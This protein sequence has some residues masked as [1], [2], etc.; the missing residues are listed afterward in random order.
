MEQGQ[1]S[2]R[3]KLLFLLESLVLAELYFCSGTFGLSLA[4]VNKSASA[5][6]PPT[7][8]ALVALLLRGYRLWPAVFVGAFAV[9]IVAQGSPTTSLVIAAGNTLEALAGAWFMLRFAGGPKALNR[10]GTIFRF[11][12]LTAMVSTIISP[13]LGV[14]SLCAGG[15]AP[16]AQCGQ[17]W[18]TWWLGDMASNLIIAPLLLVWLINPLPR[19]RPSQLIE[20]AG[21]LF[22]V[23]W[24]G[25]MVFL[26]RTP[27]GPTDYP[28]EYLAILPLLWAAF[29]FGERGALT[30]SFIISAIALWGTRHG[31]GPFNRPDPNESLLLLQTFMGTITVTTL[32]LASIIS[33]RQ[34]A[35]ERL[36]VQDAVSRVLAE[37][38]TLGEAT[39]RIFQALCEKGGW[40][41]GALWSID[42]AAGELKCAEMWHAKRVQVPEFEAAT[43]GMRLARGKG[44]PGR[45]WSSGKP[46][47]VP[48]VVKDTNFP[49]T[50]AAAH[51][52]LHGAFCFPLRLGEE[53]VAIIECFSRQVREPDDDFLQLLSALG[54]QL[55]QFIERKRAEEAQA[56]LASI[57]SSSEDAIISKTIEGRITSWNRGAEGMF[58]YSAAEAIGREIS[59]IIPP[60]RVDEEREILQRIRGGEPIRHYQTVRLRKDGALID[61]SLS[62]SPIRD[63]T[64]TITGASKIARDITQEKKTERALT[65]AQNELKEYAG[66]LE[67]RV[68]ERTAKLRETI[69]SLDGFC[70]SIAHDLRAPLRAL[71]GFSKELSEG[72]AHLLDETGNDYLS[73]I[74]AAATR[75]DQLI[76]D[77]LQFGRLN[78]AELPAKTVQLDEVLDKVL[79]PLDDEIKT[80]H[81]RVKLRKPL[82]SVR[83]NP[84]MVEQVVINL[85]GNAL[86][87]VQPKAPPKVELW[88]EAHDS[89]VR[90]YV[91]D[92]GIGI[93]PSHLNK[94]FQPFVRLVNGAEYPGTGIG[95]AIVRKAVERMGGKVGVESEPGKG[96]C[97]WIDLPAAS[98]ENS[99]SGV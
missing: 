12:L 11:V 40:E 81:A 62:I 34:R 20:G 19:P 91:K 47:W 28:L 42:H 80:K 24:I 68:Q 44:L 26:G 94:L 50:A 15:Y 87:F 43:R 48:D 98:G 85:M 54:S 52:G 76:L 13:S 92:N 6:W 31:F 79:L 49:R 8:V 93:K 7:G 9:N 70:Y 67:K 89:M 25:Q 37:A 71:G 60:D 23:V 22:L 64:G 46:V 27:F 63:A 10:T 17:I 82:L 2:I 77:L 90:L 32:V 21:L 18:I 97:F 69:Q 78:T 16:W 39:P 36:G 73:R 14:F 55:G 4:F 59:L 5:V 1:Q 33:E 51:D 99:V 30:F 41:T 45:V 66:D 35:E 75:M 83:A 56:T 88:T 86:K 53:V 74:Q 29:R 95:L 65:L 84:V 3:P 57:V 38:P 72:Y 58:G 61:V 96:S